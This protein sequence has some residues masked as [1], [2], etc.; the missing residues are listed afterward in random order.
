MQ[1]RTEEKLNSNITLSERQEG[2]KEARINIPESKLRGFC[3]RSSNNVN[4]DTDKSFKNEDDINAAE[5][6]D[7]ARQQSVVSHTA[8][9]SDIITPDD[10]MSSSLLNTA[11]K[12]SKITKTTPTA[13]TISKAQNIYR[14]RE[15]LNSIDDEE[16]ESNPDNMENGFSNTQPSDEEL[17]DFLEFIEQ[18]QPH[19]DSNE[20]EQD[21]MRKRPAS[22][23]GKTF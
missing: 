15:N 6:S 23:L 10:G 13:T 16:I 14:S 12:Q 17:K 18:G 1:K 7:D 3:L 5:K 21:Q 22:E 8:Y 4:N 2:E 19:E 20:F 9:N 11:S